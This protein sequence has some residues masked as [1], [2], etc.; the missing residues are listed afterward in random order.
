MG[1]YG[2][3]KK[4]EVLFPE[5]GLQVCFTGSGSRL[6][7]RDPQQSGLVVAL[8]WVKHILSAVQAWANGS[9]PLSLSFRMCTSMS[10][11]CG[12][13]SQ[14][15][16][17]LS[18]SLTPHFYIHY[19]ITMLCLVNLFAHLLIGLFVLLLFNLLSSLNILD[20]NPLSVE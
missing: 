16:C 6:L 1:E 20:I 12:K 3:Q 11:S 9:I 19:T 17:L 18:F 2:V 15:Q 8:A 10:Q 5:R 7:L 14:D 4:I 13:E